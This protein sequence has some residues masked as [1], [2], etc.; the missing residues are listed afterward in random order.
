VRYVG[1]TGFNS[2][3]EV[4]DVVSFLSGYTGDVKLA[5]GV[6]VSEKT[7]LG[8]SNDITPNRYPK[9]EKIKD[10]FGPTF[11]DTRFLNAIH[12]SKVTYGGINEM[13]SALKISTGAKAFQL[14]MV[15]PDKIDLLCYKGK[16]KAD[17]F[18][19]QIN[20][21]LLGKLGGSAEKVAVEVKRYNK[22]IDYIL[23]DISC[24][25]G[26]VINPYIVLKYLEKIRFLNPDIGIAVAGGLS[27][28]NLEILMPILKE[29]PDISIDA[30]TGIRNS[31]DKL[32][33]ERVKRFVDK[34]FTIL[35]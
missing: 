18:I 34:A 26:L 16:F 21:R 30:E 32:C 3:K 10:I 35:S 31:E 24:G 20:D 15:F 7:F 19:F 14:N 2:R 23:F 1:I 11:G 9:V 4:E 27:P 5:V 12:L 17:K 22:A 33:P 25:R 13:C 6:L 29:H 28:I 8:K